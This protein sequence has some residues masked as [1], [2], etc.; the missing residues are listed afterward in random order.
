M[1]RDPCLG[2]LDAPLQGLGDVLILPAVSPGCC[3]ACPGRR[4]STRG[5]SR[6]VILSWAGQEVFPC[7]QSLSQELRARSGSRLIR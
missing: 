1:R 2:L 6:G 4:F 3:P 7:T 5:C